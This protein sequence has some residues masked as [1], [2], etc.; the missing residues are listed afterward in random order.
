MLRLLQSSHREIELFSILNRQQ[1]VANS[2]RAE[3]FV[4]KIPQCVEIALGLRHLLVLDQKML[5]VKPEASEGLR[6]NGLTLCNLVLVM[7]K[8]IVDTAAMDVES[9]TEISHGHGRTF[10]VP[11]WATGAKR[12]LPLLFSV[13]FRPFPEHK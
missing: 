3:A 10:Q 8:N 11:A 4:E 9:L 1:Q 2:V 6:C 12:S 5:R 7:R 13:V